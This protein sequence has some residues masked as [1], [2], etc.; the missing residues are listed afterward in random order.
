MNSPYNI[1]I[2]KLI[3][4]TNEPRMLGLYMSPTSH[5]GFGAGTMYGNTCIQ[6]VPPH[7][8]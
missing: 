4:E 2:D 7:Q 6:Q 5:V 1:L 8:Q 3:K